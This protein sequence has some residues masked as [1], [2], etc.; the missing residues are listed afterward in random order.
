MAFGIQPLPMK[1]H[2]NATTG[3]PHPVYLTTVLKPNFQHSVTHFFRPLIE[4]NQAHAIMLAHCGIIKRGHGT[5]ILRALRQI[6]S[7]Q[8]KLEDY[9]FCGAE[10]DLFFYIESRLASRCGPDISGHL[11]V[12]RSRNDVDITLYRMVLRKELLRTAAQVDG[13]QE[14][15]LQLAEVHTKTIFPVVTHTQLAQPTTLGH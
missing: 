8:G 9:R 2:S 1:H 6:V 13:L 3:F 4:I 12:A 5:K 11:S 14:V 15:L 7:E 10:E